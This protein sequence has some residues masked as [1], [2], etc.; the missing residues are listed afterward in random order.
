MNLYNHLIF[1]FKVLRKLG[2]KSGL[3][4]LDSEVVDFR[5][6]QF[7]GQ[8]ANDLIYDSLSQNKP[9]MVA[10]FGTMEM[11]AITSI[12]TDISNLSYQKIKEFLRFKISLYR[13]QTFK[14]LQSNAGFFPNNE[15]NVRKFVDLMIDIIPDIDILSSYIY[16]EKYIEYLLSPKCKRIDLDG[17]Y[18]PWLFKNPWTRIL[19]GKKVLVVHPFVDSI[20]KQYNENRAKLFK[21]P[22][23]LPEFK[24]LI[25]VEAVQSIGGKSNSFNNW[26]EALESMKEAISKQDFDIALIGCGAYG[27]PLASFVKRLGKQAI[28]MGGWVQML[29]GIYG[30]RW[31]EDQPQYKSVIND[32]WVRP[33]EK[34]KPLDADK[35]E[36]GCYW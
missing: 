3:I 11:N 23:V 18:A 9:L 19:K 12:Q 6:V 34:E 14:S 17:L 27:M 30:K 13:P 16:A 35:V 32:F 33:K 29:F 22:D 7:Y 5:Y 28:H 2:I 25:V 31:I 10:K 36:G 20:T 24:S 8:I 1:N 15:T 4:K 26:F 21:D